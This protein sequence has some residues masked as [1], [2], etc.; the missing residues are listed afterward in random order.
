[1]KSVFSHKLTTLLAVVLAVML[2][3]CGGSDDTMDEATPTMM[4][5]VESNADKQMRLIADASAGLTAALAALDEDAPTATQIADV[6][7]AINLL[8]NALGGAHDLTPTQTASARSAL[9]AARTTVSGARTT[10]G[11]Q[12]TLAERRTMQ[13]GAIRTAQTALMTALGALDAT[14]PATIA[15]VNTAYDMLKAEIDR[16]N[17]LTDAEKMMA[18]SELRD[19]DVDIA[20]AELASATSATEATGATDAEMLKA[21]ED[22]RDAAARLLAAL[23]ANNGSAADIET[24]TRTHQS[25]QDKVASLTTK[26]GTADRLAKNALSMAVATAINAH[27]L[28]VT[29]REFSRGNADGEPNLTI[30]RISGDAVFTLAQTDAQK[31]TKPYTMS[32]APSAGVGWM[33]KTF[34]HSGTDVNR[35]FTEMAAVYTDIKMAGD[36]AWTTEGFT[37]HPAITGVVTDA[38]VTITT[39]DGNMLDASRFSGSGVLPAPPAPDNSGGTKVLP[40]APVPGSFFGVNGNFS[41]TG[42]CTVTRNKAGKISVSAALTFTPTGAVPAGGRMAKYADPDSDY[43]YFGYWMKSVTTQRNGITHDI[44]TFYGGGGTVP[45]G[46]TGT[47][48]LGT[49]KYYG[50]ASGV[51]VKKAGSAD[52]LV[53]TDGA[54]TADA[55]LE[56]KFGGNTVLGSEHLTVSGRI[57]DFMDG[58]TDLEFAD[59]ML[60]APQAADGTGSIG[61]TGAFSGSTNGGGRTGSWTGQFY[62]SAA[63]GTGDT[64]TT[65]DYPTDVAGEFNGH[66]VNGHVAGAFGAELDH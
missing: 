50:A 61:E 62:G 42:G 7:R 47:S 17:D 55:M 29:P 31:R 5:P 46:I 33:G 39:T 43:T 4:D 53:V 48:L 12:M 65:D 32:A 30:S 14:D 60:S 24:A 3:G 16:G 59:L 27:T 36:T 22:K 52:E 41:C 56:A 23:K 49:A 64:V 2:A 58:S 8:A 40:N 63:G 1:M 38:A 57:S 26:V 54:F 34:T 15:E 11:S 21:Y 37:G 44:E 9:A 13:S 51:Y 45:S 10:L 25:A 18:R 19:A 6:Q 28:G 35:P 66:F 20:K